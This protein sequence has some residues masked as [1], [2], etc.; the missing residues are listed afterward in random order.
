M[1]PIRTILVALASTEYCRGILNYA[2]TLASALDA[3]ILI[4]SVVNSRDIDAVRQVASMGY[5]VDGEN[6]VSG[7]KA[8][9]RKD[10]DG[11]LEK[12]IFPK[13]RVRIVMPVGNP[14]E[15]LLKLM[16]RESVEMVVMGIK[17]RTD[18]EHILMGSV[19]EK[20]F[21]RSPV[22]VVSYRDETQAQQLR[23]R[24]HV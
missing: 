6:Y 3:D 14:V 11:I 16:V 9:R 24:I 17:G 15:E 10:I 5:A 7:V 4:A 2:A 13:E 22:T 20:V 18:L 19:A 21:R 8:A 23:K 12:V 1:G